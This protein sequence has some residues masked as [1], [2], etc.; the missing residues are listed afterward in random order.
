MVLGFKHVDVALTALYINMLPGLL[1]LMVVTSMLML[2]LV[3]TVQGQK[4]RM[5]FVN[6][7]VITQW[8][9]NLIFSRGLSSRPHVTC[10]AL[11]KSFLFR[12]T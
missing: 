9:H 3:H 5:L 8:P 11:D 7:G 6:A 12:H 2:Y 10:M 4:S 1:N